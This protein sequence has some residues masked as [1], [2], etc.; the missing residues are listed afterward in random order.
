MV[1]IL[2]TDGKLN[3]TCRSASN[4]F[5]PVTEEEF[6]GVSDLVR[7]RS[8]LE[9]VNQVRRFYNTLHPV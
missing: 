8:K 3:T 9:D 7:G 1:L 2:R 5:L 6:M 4:D